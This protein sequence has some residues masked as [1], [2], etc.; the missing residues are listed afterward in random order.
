MI[1]REFKV[2]IEDGHHTDF[3]NDDWT[4]GEQLLVFSRIFA[5]PTSKVGCVS[6]FGC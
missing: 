3:W 4:G 1:S 2:L 6:D 5:L